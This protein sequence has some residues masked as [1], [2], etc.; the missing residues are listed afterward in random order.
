MFEIKII[1]KNNRPDKA[2]AYSND[3]NRRPLK[4]WLSPFPV[5]LPRIQTAL[6]N[7]VIV[8]GIEKCAAKYSQH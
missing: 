2:V 7:I 1:K 5:S 6:E 8:Q 4:I 3:N